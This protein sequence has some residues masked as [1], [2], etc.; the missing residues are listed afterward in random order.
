MAG[1][2]Y[3]AL[4]LGHVRSDW[5]SELSRW[6]TSAAVPVEFVKT[7][8]VEEVRARLDSGR[9]FS[10][11]LVDARVPGLDRD[12]VDRSRDAGCSVIVVDDG[13][14]VRDW[15]ALGVSAV[16]RDGFARE[17]LLEVLE[18]HAAM[19]GRGDDLPGPATAADNVVS[20]WRGRLVA[21]TGAGG[22][23]T[24][25]L[26][27]ALSQALGDDPRF[28]DMVVLADLALDAD[29]AM[30]HDAREVVPGVQELAEAH[31]SAVLSPDEV[32]ALTFAVVERRYH[33]LLGLR[34]HRDWTALR[35][36]A[37]EAALEGLRRSFRMVVCDV[38]PDVEGEDQ[39]GSADVEERNLMARTAVA[40]ADA[41]L[42]VGTAGLKGLHSLVRVVSSLQGHGVDHGRL[43]PVVN[44]APRQPRARAEISRAL[45]ELVGRDHALAGP[46]FVPERRRLDD[47]LRDGARLPDQLG[48]VLVGAVH[49]V[50][51]RSDPV[52]APAEPEPVA[53]APGELGSWSDEG[54]A[55]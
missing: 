48:A 25:T 21:V 1:E 40:R 15:R 2:R 27:M 54:T 17:D 28:A 42:V 30:L 26:A 50:L 37:F 31:R 20:A 16:L 19:I 47:V 18:A 6:S 4:G 11:L 12:L 55:G 24:S 49:A 8:S 10:A 38:D 13:R 7:V 29:L 34:R 36:R 51:D 45:A 3:V 9:A 46:V 35:P 43:I 39:C 53:V 41:V 33:L 22:T 52:A 23:G 44:R 5:F 14:V 32:R